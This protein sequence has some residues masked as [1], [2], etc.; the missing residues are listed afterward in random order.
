MRIS[1][2]LS[3]YWYKIFTS[4]YTNLHEKT[5]VAELLTLSTEY[6]IYKSEIEPWYKQPF[7]FDIYVKLKRRQNRP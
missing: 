5:H 3:L 7:Y 1:Y 4:I 2:K 6:F